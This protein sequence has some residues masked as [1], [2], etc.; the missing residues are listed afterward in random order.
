MTDKEKQE[1]EELQMHLWNAYE[2][3]NNIL[4]DYAEGAENAK[5]LVPQKR[6]SEKTEM[7]ITRYL[8]RIGISPLGKGYVYLREAIK[9]TIKDPSVCGNLS[10]KI[11]PAIA[12]ANN[13]TAK[14]VG[15]AIDHAIK[16]CF[17]KEK[18]S[19]FMQDVFGY[20][21][22]DTQYVPSVGEFIIIIADRIKMQNR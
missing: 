8:Q 21:M 12:T 6:I 5:K 14:G 10:K 15:K 9:M 7:E 3:I 2:L 11:Y 17:K 20:I 1:L 19:K 13:T 18:K 16:S 4:D 22:E